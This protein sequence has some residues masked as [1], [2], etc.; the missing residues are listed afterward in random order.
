MIGSN[1]SAMIALLLILV[2]MII[3]MRHPSPA[4]RATSNSPAPMATAPVVRAR[5]AEICGDLRDVSHYLISRINQCILFACG[6]S[7][8]SFDGI[9]DA[10]ALHHQFPGK[11]ALGEA[12]LAGDKTGHSI[13]ILFSKFCANKPMDVPKLTPWLYAAVLGWGIDAPLD[14]PVFICTV[15]CTGGLKWKR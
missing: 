12:Q 8:A 6:D 2:R 4:A 1:N 7:F 10:R 11:L 9:A 14:I 5:S 15:I 13:D 3:Q